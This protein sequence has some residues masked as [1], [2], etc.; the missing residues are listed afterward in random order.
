M[1]FKNNEYIR[2]SVV[3]FEP[4]IDNRL[5]YYQEKSNEK[6]D[7]IILFERWGTQKSK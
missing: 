4:N 7:N 5:F 1:C 2:N 6:N 3:C